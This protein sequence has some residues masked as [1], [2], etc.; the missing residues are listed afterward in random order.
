L[1]T[2]QHCISTEEGEQQTF[3]TSHLPDPKTL[4]R[5]SENPSGHVMIYF[6]FLVINIPPSQILSVSSEDDINGLQEGPA[7]TS[8]R[9]R[10]TTMNTEIS[11]FICPPEG[12]ECG[13]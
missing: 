10:N 7:E 12:W 3:V 6:R 11:C 13:L 1:N 4:D 5:K 8:A 2:G 9:H